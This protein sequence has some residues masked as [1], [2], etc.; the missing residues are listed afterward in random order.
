VTELR[1]STSYS[2]NV[3]VNVEGYGANAT[4]VPGP[5]AKARELG[6]VG[7][8]HILIA[9]ASKIEP[10]IG[11][12]GFDANGKWGWLGIASNFQATFAQE[13]GHAAYNMSQWGVGPRSQTVSGEW[14]IRFRNAYVTDPRSV[15]AVLYRPGGM[16]IQWRPHP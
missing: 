9:P 13:L 3:Y 5:S 11:G 16:P 4:T 8:S 12:A 2:V 7:G 15:P 14:A 10:A 6:P 1:D